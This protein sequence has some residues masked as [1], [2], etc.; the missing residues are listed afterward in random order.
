[1]VEVQTQKNGDEW[2]RLLQLIQGRGDG[3]LDQG[4][5]GDKWSKYSHFEE[6]RQDY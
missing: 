6:D 2:R 1:M 3:G 5:G 4:S